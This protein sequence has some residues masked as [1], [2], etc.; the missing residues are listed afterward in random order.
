[1]DSIA[2]FNDNAL[3]YSPN[4]L[5]I[6]LALLLSFFILLIVNAFGFFVKNVRYITKNIIKVQK[7]RKQKKREKAKHNRIRLLIK[8]AGIMYK[9]LNKKKKK[10]ILNSR[11]IINAI[12][13]EILIKEGEKI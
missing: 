6:F 13:E 5:F 7:I 4:V 3:I 12:K 9:I 8:T 10:I 2:L 1:M 11:T